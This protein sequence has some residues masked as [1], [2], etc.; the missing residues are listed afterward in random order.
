M[1]VTA[2]QVYDL[3]LAL[4]DEVTESGLAEPDNPNYYKAKSVSFLTILQAELLPISET[5]APVTD[6]A[7]TLQLSD[8]L[9]LTVLPYGLAAHLLLSEDASLASFLNGRYDELKRKMPT[10]AVAITDN[11]NVL[12]R[13]G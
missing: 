8:R 2:K 5:P 9:C 11:Y 3:S 12:S 13:E 10:K 4:I 7:G 1:A 6:L